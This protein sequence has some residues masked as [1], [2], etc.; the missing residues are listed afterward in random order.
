M[1]KLRMK[2]GA[3][4]ILV[5][6]GVLCT[7][8]FAEPGSDSDPLISKSY[9]DDVLM[10]KIQD[11]IDSKV[12]G[13]GNTDSAKFVVVEASAGKKIICEAGTELILRMGK[14]T[15]IATEKG[16]LADTTIGDDLPDGK[17][18]PSNHLLIVPVADGRGIKADTDVI[19]MIKGGYSIK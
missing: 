3:F 19:V 4:V 5:C 10:P 6:I 17:K 11:M 9:V 14:A 7:A 2:L 18:M 12:A 8:V 13:N 16:G 1:K 15:V